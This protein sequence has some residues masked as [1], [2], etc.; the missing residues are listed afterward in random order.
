MAAMS[1]QGLLIVWI[2]VGVL[3][4]SAD[5]YGESRALITFPPLLIYLIGGV[6]GDRVDA[7]RLLIVLTALTAV[8]PV[9]LAAVADVINIWLVIAF[10]AS[11]ALLGALA[12]PTRQGIINR[13]SHLDVQRSIAIVA[14]VPSLVS[15]AAMTL[16]IKVEEL[17]LAPVLLTIALFY[18]LAAVAFLGLP[19]LQPDADERVSV[20]EGFRASMGIPL[21]RRLIGMNFVSAIFNAGGYMVVMPYILMENY[22]GG[23]LPVDDDALFTAMFIAFTIGSTGSMIVLFW[24]MPLRLPGRVFLALQLFRVFVILGIWIQPSPWLFMTFV[25][26]WGINMGVTS[27]LVRSTIQELAPPS[28]RA[29]VLGFYL[30]SFTLSGILASLILG[31]IVEW[32]GAINALLPGVAIS[33]G[34]FLYGYRWSGYWDYRSNSAVA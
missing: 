18:A 22:A 23:V 12:D 14:I 4:E 7:R 17:G 6:A 20:L 29:K 13:V 15:I 16:G 11:T 25:M 31:Y 34:L 2:L 28:H 8:V 5:V 1:L 10:G 33:I 3:Q 27:T 24:L 26:L 9:L 19:T 21:V 30:F 32:I